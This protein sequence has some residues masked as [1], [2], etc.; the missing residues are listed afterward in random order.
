MAVTAPVISKH[1][2][3]IIDVLVET[4]DDFQN[5]TCYTSLSLA[6]QGMWEND[7]GY[8]YSD[9]LAD[10]GNEDQIAQAQEAYDACNRNYR[11]YEENPYRGIEEVLCRRDE[12]RAELEMSA[13]DRGHL[14]RRWWDPDS[15]IVEG[16]WYCPNPYEG[17]EM[18]LTCADL[19]AKN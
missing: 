15:K 17:G 19:D 6:H 3:E 1:D 9:A 4:A 10:A 8:V 11:L 16:A 18:I 7:C 13:D 14:W 12:L 2:R 5:G